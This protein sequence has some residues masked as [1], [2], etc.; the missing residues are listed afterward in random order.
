[1]RAGGGW[2]KG[3]KRM[4]W[5]LGKEVGQRGAD[6]MSTVPNQGN[7][8]ERKKNGPVSKFGSSLCTP[9]EYTA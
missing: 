7:A 8:C 3:A 4:K 2:T 5:A 6:A 9:K 1:M